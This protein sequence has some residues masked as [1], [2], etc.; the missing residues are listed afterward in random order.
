MSLLEAPLEFPLGGGGDGATIPAGAYA[1]MMMGLL[2]PGRVWRLVAESFL[3]SLFLACADE[4]ER[5]DESASDLLNEADPSTAVALLTEYERELGI[6]AEGTVEER[7]ARIVS[8]LV[9][10]QRYRPVDF[11]AALAPIL[12]QL[13]ADVVVLERTH[14]MAASLGD[15]REIFIFFIYRDPTLPGT[16]Y[17]DSAQELVDTIKP[18]HTIGHVVESIDFCCDDPYS[19]CDRDLLGA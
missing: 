19:Q 17:L 3:S 15:D 5:Y 9:A 12:G 10:R 13:A 2:P 8:R 7:Q 4:L 11:Q 6:E 16:Y 1:R 18:S 14:A